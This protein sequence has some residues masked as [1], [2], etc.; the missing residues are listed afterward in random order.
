MD[1]NTTATIFVILTSLGI[2]FIPLIV[3]LGRYHHQ[4]TAIVMLNIF[5]GWTLLGWIIA[6]IWACT[7]VRESHG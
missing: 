6:L 7:E 4:R 3:A 5:L 1:T 2:Y